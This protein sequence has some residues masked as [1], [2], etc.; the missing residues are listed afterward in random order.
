MRCRHRR[1]RLHA[2]T[3]TDS[4]RTLSR[5]IDILVTNNADDGRALLM[6]P[7]APRLAKGPNSFV[8]FNLTAAFASSKP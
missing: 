6:F 7:G 1:Q 4:R 3:S 5:R 2:E 8:K